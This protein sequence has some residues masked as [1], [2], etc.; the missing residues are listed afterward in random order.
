VGPAP[1]PPQ[2]SKYP[3]PPGGG[4]DAN[5]FDTKTYFLTFRLLKWIQQASHATQGDV[6]FDIGAGDGR[7]LTVGSTLFESCL[8]IELDPVLYRRAFTNISRRRFS[9]STLEIYNGDATDPQHLSLY[10]RGTVFY[11][12]N[13]FGAATLNRFLSL[14]QQTTAARHR[15]LHIFYLHPHPEHIQA[16]R[17]TN[18]LTE[19]ETKSIGRLQVTHFLH[20]RVQ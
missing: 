5:W 20:R 18:W 13:P 19:V 16:L 3:R 1:P 14:L 7:V 12:C 15:P 17:A 8:G 9:R 2:G 10:N 4:E 6:L 11:L